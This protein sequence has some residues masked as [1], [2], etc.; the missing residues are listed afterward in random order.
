MRLSCAWTNRQHSIRKPARVEIIL[1]QDADILS[2][3]SVCRNVI[4]VNS[5]LIEDASEIRIESLRSR[6]GKAAAEVP[7]RAWLPDGLLS[8]AVG[9]NHVHIMSAVVV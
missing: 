5:L 3:L 8:E 1:M 7:P 9:R 6:E 2:V 4:G